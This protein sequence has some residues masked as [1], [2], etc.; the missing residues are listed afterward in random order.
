MVLI[1]TTF[2]SRILHQYFC[3]KKLQSRYE[4]REKLYKTLLNKKFERKMLM[5]VTPGVF[6][7]NLP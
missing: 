3:A 5:K 4:T 6:G 2:F 1:L 7:I